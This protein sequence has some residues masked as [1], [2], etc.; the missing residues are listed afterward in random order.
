MARAADETQIEVERGV[1]RVV[2]EERG[3]RSLRRWMVDCPRG[4]SKDL[5]VCG[6]CPDCRGYTLQGPEGSTIVCTLWSSEEV[7]GA[8]VG[9]VGGAMLREVLC[10]APELPAAAALP[11]LGEH[12]LG[13]PVLDAADRPVGVFGPFARKR[14][15]RGKRTTVRDLMT[16]PAL[17]ARELEPLAPVQARMKAAGARLL[18]VVDDDGRAIG[19]LIGEA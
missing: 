17:S 13:L 10:L 5:N 2:V 11:L 14:A 3:G 19:V 1:H 12:P 9:T 4:R 18:V 7:G 15:V 6:R 16:A 8:P